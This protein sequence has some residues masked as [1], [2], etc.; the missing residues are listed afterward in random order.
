[1]LHLVTRAHRL[2]VRA[3]RLS[4]FPED[5]QPAL[6]QA[7]QRAGMR[8]AFFA[9]GFVIGVRPRAAMPA[10][11]DPQMHGGAEGVIAGVSDLL[12]TDFSGLDRD[13]RRA[14]KSLHGLGVAEA[15]AVVAELGE[16]ARSELR[17]GARQGAEE[18]VI[19]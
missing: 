3:A 7:A 19:G 15:R 4:H 16:Q 18:I 10:V 13:R 1:M 5:F 6:T 11:V 9:M 8:L 2:V 17:A 12:I 14:G